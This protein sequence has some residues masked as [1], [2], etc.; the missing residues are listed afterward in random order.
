MGELLEGTTTARIVRYP[1]CRK[2]LRKSTF[3][4]LSWESS[5]TEIKQTFDII[6]TSNNFMI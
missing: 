1:H 4:N 6:L 2:H 5:T 3:E